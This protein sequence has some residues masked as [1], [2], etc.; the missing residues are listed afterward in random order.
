MA[1]RGRRPVLDGYK[2]REILA[3]LAV[4]CSRSTAAKYVGCALST[5]QNT[6]DRDP[7]FAKQLRQNEHASEI[8]Y[9]ENIRR[10]ARNERY[11]RAA[12]W[13]LE[14]LDPEQYGRRSPEVITLDQIGRLLAQ[15][16]EI[17]VEE[18]PVEKYRKA[19]LKRFDAL[20]GDLK[21]ASKKRGATDDKT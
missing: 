17:V 7:G 3:I 15:F 16:A 19:I 2:R 10:A 6:A 21:E 14:R 9:M 12:A 5:I 13:A 20:T 18:V 1:K 11:W 8:G 4:G